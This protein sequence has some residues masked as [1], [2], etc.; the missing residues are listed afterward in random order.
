[1]LDLPGS[2][3]VGR[4]IIAEQGMSDRV[5]HVE[6]DMMSADLGGPHDGA[7]VFNIVHH[8]SPERER[9]AAAP[10]PRGAEA[11]GTVAVLDL[12]LPEDD[13]RPDAAACS[14]CSSI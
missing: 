8:L 9:R 2:A 5:Q 14:A 11:G 13:R 10:H 6:G 1:M 3:A 12:W 7:L 4:R